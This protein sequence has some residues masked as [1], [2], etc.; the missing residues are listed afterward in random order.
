MRRLSRRGGVA[1]CAG[2]G[3]LLAS[4]G[5]A[6]AAFPGRPGQL[7]VEPLSGPGVVL[8]GTN[9]R[10]AK[11]ICG[12]GSACNL[13][14]RARPMWS[15]DGRSLL[16]STSGGVGVVYPDGSCLDCHPLQASS[17]G[18]PTNAGGGAFTSDPT[19]ITTVATGKLLQYGVDGIFKR[20]LIGGGVAEAAW[21]SR[22]KL[23]VVR[24][25]AIWVGKPGSLRRLGSGTDPAWSPDGV[26]IVF[27]RNGWVM[28]GRARGRSFKRLAKG[29]APAFSPGGGTI[30]FI[31]NRHRLSLIPAHGGQIRRV[32]GVKGNA[33][34]W[35]PLP[36]TPSSSCLAPRGSKVIA[37]DGTAI[38]TSDTGPAQLPFP[39][40]GYDASAYMGCLVA[41]G[42]ARLLARYD[43]QDVDGSEVATEAA[44]A[45]NYAALIDQVVDGH[46]GGGGST[47]RVFDLRTGSS[48]PH[49]G[50]QNV[51][52]P[53]RSC[54]ETM[55]SLVLNDQGFTAVRVWLTGTEQVVAS[56]SAGLLTVDSAAN[57][58][59]DQP[60]L[61]NLTLAGDTLS[62]NHDGTPKSTE[63]H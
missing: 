21:S 28:V 60:G 41:D 19:L 4:C 13:G 1:V 31:D 16:L 57:P 26:R 25:G 59:P 49:L 48:A 44:V 10:G 18:Q 6:Q 33:V 14:G 29:S 37:S 63:L 43:V 36:G 42:R 39:E 8:V 62:W 56:D 22:G 20:T 7:A 47:V 38:V 54:Y 52:C 50:G 32:G 23:A 55:D 27:V 58:N 15:P 34:D 2:L 40:A 45:G 35:Q 61:T 5:I 53:D 51:S 3:V 9:G 30:A 12:R 17:Q 11:L 46:Y 24:L